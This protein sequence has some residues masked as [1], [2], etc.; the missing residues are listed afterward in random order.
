MSGALNVIDPLGF[1]GG[2]QKH[3]TDDGVAGE[4]KPTGA[5][6]GGQGN[7]WTVEVR[8]G[9]APALTLVAVMA[10]R[11]AVV[12]GGEVSDAVR[13]YSPTEFLAKDFAGESPA[14]RKIHRREKIP[15]GH[16][17]Q[18]FAG[19][20]YADEELDL[21]V[22][23]REV[24]VADGPILL[25]PVAAGSFELVIAVAIALARPAEGFAADLAAANPHKGFVNRKSVG[26]LAIVD[27]KLVTV[28]IASVTEPLHGLTLEQCLA[29]AEAAIFQLVRPDVL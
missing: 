10:S 22:V 8:S 4:R 3:M 21:L 17:R 6:S 12:D 23:R 28:F 2:I 9:V 25:V 29:V 7:A 5:R 27:K 20:A 16:L 19:A 14:A 24:F 26:I 18:T 1:A 15:V 11:A 13:C